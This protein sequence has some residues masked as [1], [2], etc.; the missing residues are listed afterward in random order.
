MN[1][2]S[3]IV[4]SKYT[5]EICTKIKTTMEINFDISKEL[6]GKTALVTG[7][8]KGAGKA[9]AERLSKAG[10][11]VIIT[12]RNKPGLHNS[13]FHFIQADLS[14]PEGTEKL[15]GEIQET[16]GGVD[17]LV[18]NLGGSETPGGGFQV[19][20]DP[21]G[22]KLSIQIFWHPLDLTEVYCLIC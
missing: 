18:N 15:I 22:R 6:S 3:V 9:I 1:I 8:T 19:L 14:R 5:I 20:T 17:I 12:A 10:A 2:Y 7:G 11:K 13:T 16:Y 21:I 4:R